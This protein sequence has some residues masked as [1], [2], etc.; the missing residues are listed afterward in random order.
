MLPTWT[1]DIS[2]HNDKIDAQHK[3]LFE[4][5]GR[6]YMMTEKVKQRRGD[7]GIA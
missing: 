1:K 6:A 4:I 7:W 2:V 5:A 3:K